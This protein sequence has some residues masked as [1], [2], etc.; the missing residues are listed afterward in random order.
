MWTT[1][2]SGA[3]NV[4]IDA[5]NVDGSK[6]ILLVMDNRSTAIT[7]TCGKFYIGTSDSAASGSTFAYPYSAAKLH[8]LQVQSTRSG[9]TDAAFPSTG[10]KAQLTV[11]GPFETARFKSSA[12]YIKFCKRKS[13]GDAG[14][15]YVCPILIK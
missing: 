15:V 9:D 14:N 4:Y 1:L 6:L 10:G 11:L 7:A 2:A 3:N 8:R 13:A 12:G 5:N